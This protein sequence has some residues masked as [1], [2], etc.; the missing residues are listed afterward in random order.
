MRRKE[1]D[2]KGRKTSRKRKR[3]KREKTKEKEN[4]EDKLVY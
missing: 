4:G 1:I 3:C 2:G